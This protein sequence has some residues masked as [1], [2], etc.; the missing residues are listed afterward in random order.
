MIRACRAGPVQPFSSVSRA[1][2]ISSR[3]RG[4]LAGQS[5]SRLRGARTSAPR[6]VHRALGL[7]PAVKGGPRRSR[8]RT[9]ANPSRI[10]RLSPSPSISLTLSL[11]LFAPCYRGTRARD[12]R[13]TRVVGTTRVCVYHRCAARVALPQVRISRR[14]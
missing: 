1:Q 3:W 5:P 6:V 4:F 2:L 13:D 7:T 14:I 8:S 9:H 10:S 11:A 12:A